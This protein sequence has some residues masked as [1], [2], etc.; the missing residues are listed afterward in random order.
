MQDREVDL[1]KE[2]K[3]LIIELANSLPGPKVLYVDDDMGYG[4]FA[5]RDYN[6]GEIV[7]YY[8]GVKGVKAKGDYVVDV[9]DIKTFDSEYIF[10][11]SEKGR[12]INSSK[13]NF[14]VE[15]K[16]R[17]K[18]VVAITTKPV[19]S[20]EQFFINYGKY[21]VFPE[22]EKTI[23][24]RLTQIN[25]DIL[26]IIDILNIQKLPPIF[27]TLNSEK[28]INAPFQFELF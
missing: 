26:G 18:K 28:K 9:N 12:W 3:K 14:N 5:E 19:K 21:Y 22:K 7:T 24:D 16:Y 8:G 25:N 4:L 23:L 15:F 17:N 13:Y 2:D 6:E 10:K 1:R 20:G 11:I 27:T